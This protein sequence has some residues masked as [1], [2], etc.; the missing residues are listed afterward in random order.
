MDN[1]EPC[2]YPASDCHFASQMDKH[3]DAIHELTQKL[4]KLQSQYTDM[5][6][7]A[8][9]LAKDLLDA[10][11]LHLADEQSVR[12]MEAEIERLNRSNT[13]LSDH[14]E[15]TVDEYAASTK[16]FI[17]ECERLNK[18]A[19]DITRAYMD[20]RAK[21]ESANLQVRAYR[22][23]L[24]KI[25]CAECTIHDE[26][27]EKLSCPTLEYCACDARVAG[28]A[29]GDDECPVNP[30]GANTRV[31]VCGK[32]AGCALESGHRGLCAE[33]RFK[34]GPANW[35]KIIG[36]L[37]DLQEPKN[38][39]ATEIVARR[40]E[41]YGPCEHGCGLE[42]GHNVPC[43]NKRK[44]RCAVCHEHDDLKTHVCKPSLR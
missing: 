25:A 44:D 37:P 36:A 18:E 13:A 28:H 19:A 10:D 20:A 23:A 31:G 38:M 7:R 5:T 9:R 11:E 35:D 6:G 1:M 14:L 42:K 17:A 2:G 22:E 43:P 41:F 29:I 21:E 12:N 26:Y 34:S 3:R 15:K 39:T 4:E 24:H 40:I 8:E 32:M 33:N 30:Q 27:C 16:R